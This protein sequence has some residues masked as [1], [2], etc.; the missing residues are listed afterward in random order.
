MLT[1]LVALL[2]LLSALAVLGQ[3]R[4]Q[5]TSYTRGLE[6]EPVRGRIT[7]IV[8]GETVKVLT[9]AKQRA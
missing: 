6:Q 2:V 4:L 7:G 3:N 8:D 5:P 1:R 9:A